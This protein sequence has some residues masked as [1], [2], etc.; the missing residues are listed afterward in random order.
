MKPFLRA[1][2]QSLKYKWSIAG[3]FLCSFLIAIIWSASITTV[4]PIVKIVLEDETA[5][6]WVDNSIQT[7]EVS[8]QALDAEVADLNAEFE[9]TNDSPSISNRIELKQDRIHAEKKSLEWFR[10][11]QPFVTKYAPTSP[12]QTL[13]WA[14]AW[15]LIVSCIKGVLLVISAILDARVAERTVFDMRRIFYRKGLEL[16]QRR[17]DVIGTSNM[18]TQLSYNMMMISSGL[19][20]FYGK[21]FREPL[22]MISCLVCARR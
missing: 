5:I 6:S 15:L 16:D 22:K 8:L 3:A 2:K 18:M 21:C 14:L 9:Q 20:M 12:F 1:I 4:F 19:R 13:C 11:V 7:Y 10:K 17:I